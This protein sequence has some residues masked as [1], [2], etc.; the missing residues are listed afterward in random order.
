MV[1]GARGCM[2]SSAAFSS[3][4]HVAG[5][6]AKQLGLEPVPI[7]NAGPMLAE[8]QYAV[9]PQQLEKEHQVDRSE[10]RLE[11]ILNGKHL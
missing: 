4:K 8:D 1:A 6:E 9:L 7:C 2:P 3:H 5:S 10:Q 11:S